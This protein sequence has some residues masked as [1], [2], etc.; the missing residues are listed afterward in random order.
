MVLRQLKKTTPDERSA[1]YDRTVRL[2]LI[3][4]AL[5]IIFIIL[6]WSS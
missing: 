3:G 6:W 4:V 2:E 5:L 1:L